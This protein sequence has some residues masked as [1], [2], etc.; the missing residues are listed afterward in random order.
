[1][2]K[3]ILKTATFIFVLSI[4]T[5]GYSQELSPMNPWLNGFTKTFKSAWQIHYD[6]K[7]STIDTTSKIEPFYYADGRLAHIVFSDY[8]VAKHQFHGI[9]KTIFYYNA[10]KQQDSAI[11][12][13]INPQG[14]IDGFLDR[15]T[16]FYG[17]SQKVWDSMAVSY[18]D[19][20][21]KVYASKSYVLRKLDGDTIKVESQYSSTGKEE[22]LHS[23]TY[24]NGKITAASFK[25]WDAGTS[26]YIAN[27]NLSINYDGSGKI[28]KYKLDR[29]TAALSDSFVISFDNSG[30]NTGIEQN[31]FAGSNKISVYPNPTLGEVNILL[32]A[33]AKQ[34][35]VSIYNTIGQL[36]IQEN[37]IQQNHINISSLPNGIYL[38]RVIADGKLYDQKIIKE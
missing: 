11:T 4:C 31:N 19:T 5:K 33:V 20:T 23:F 13:R 10:K 7:K 38:L 35:S 9:S 27:M 24:T 30:I 17:T 37:L 34:S 8:D 32:N 16:Y 26:A 1:M 15:K 29:N 6:E 18:F 28:S 12:Y 3:T 14:I 2:I 22:R 21:A 36:V 25:T